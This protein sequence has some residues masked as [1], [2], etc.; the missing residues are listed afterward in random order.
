LRDPQDKRGQKRLG[1]TEYFRRERGPQKE[2]LRILLPPAPPLE[3]KSMIKRVGSVI[4]DE[5][6]FVN[7]KKELVQIIFCH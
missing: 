1:I 7:I 6:Y 4:L 3:G 2:V 5:E